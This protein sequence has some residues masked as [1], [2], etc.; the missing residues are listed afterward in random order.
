MLLH[1]IFEDIWVYIH[2]QNDMHNA[3]PTIMVGDNTRQINLNLQN[4]DELQKTTVYNSSIWSWRPWKTNVYRAL[5]LGN[6][7]TIFV[8]NPRCRLCSGRSLGRW[9]LVD[10]ARRRTSKFDVSSCELPEALPFLQ[11]LTLWLYEDYICDW[12]GYE[13]TLIY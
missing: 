3:S 7:I 5:F 2:I 4:H 1:C 13:N 6:S 9:G 11:L 10:P 12:E 8:L